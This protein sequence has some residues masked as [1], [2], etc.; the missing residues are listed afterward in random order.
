[1]ECSHCRFDNPKGMNFC[2]NCG[3]PLTATA[4]PVL[5]DYANRSPR[6]YT[7][8]F[9]LEKILVNRAALEGE[10][11]H[12]SVFFADVAGFTT[13]SENLDPEDV[14]EIMDGCFEILG[15]EIHGAGGAINQYTGDGVMALFGAPIAYEDHINRACHAALRIQ[16]RMKGYTHDVKTQYGVL[17]QMRIGINAG[18]VVV[19][20]HRRQPEA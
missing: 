3:Q 18:T 9:L 1:M 16:R 13:L 20:R 14:H 17:F 11:K 10:R 8:P 4:P 6:D 19:G 2:G 12:V 5:P 7:P 15:Q